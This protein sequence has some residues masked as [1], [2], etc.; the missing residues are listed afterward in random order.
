MRPFHYV[1]YVVDT[2]L[3]DTGYCLPAEASAEAGILGTMKKWNIGI[4]ETRFFHFF[5]L[6]SSFFGLNLNYIILYSKLH[7]VDRTFKVKLLHYMV[8]VR[9]NGPNTD[10]KFIGNILV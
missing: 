7:Q 1:F 9:F 3:M 5:G 4:L 2:R 10:K 6:R 8:F